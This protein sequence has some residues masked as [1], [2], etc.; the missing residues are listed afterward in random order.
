M[1]DVKNGGAVHIGAVPL[2]FLD[3]MIGVVMGFDPKILESFGQ[4][5][6]GLGNLENFL[7]SQAIW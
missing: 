4:E 2:G 7:A 5:G 6:A 1:G 3:L